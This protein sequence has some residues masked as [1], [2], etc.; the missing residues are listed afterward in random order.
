MSR[1]EFARRVGVT[2]LTIYR[3]ELPLDADESRRPRKR[4]RARLQQLAADGMADPVAEAPVADAPVAGQ[5]GAE[6][7]PR[8][9]EAS[10]RTRPRRPLRPVP[11]SP[12]IDLSDEKP[13]VHSG[14]LA[15]HERAAI[16]PVLGDIAYANWERAEEELIE[17]LAAGRLE[18]SGRALA[19]LSMA[20]IQL[21]GRNDARGAFS[22]LLP[23]LTTAALGELSEAAAFRAHMVAT[24]LF[25]TPYGQLFDAGRVRA[26]LARG[27]RLP[28]PHGGDDMRILL[29][30]GQLQGPYHLGDQALFA[31]RLLRDRAELEA[32]DQPVARCLVE[33][34]LARAAYLEGHLA[35]AQKRFMA[36]AERA[37][38]R[39]FSLV[40]GQALAYAALQTLESA[41]PADSALSLCDRA[42][43][44]AERARLEPGAHQLLL[45][46]V[47]A[48]AHLRL[49]QRGAAQ[50][51]LAR[52]I[53]LAER[54]G[55]PPIDLLFG[56]V[57]A[58]TSPEF[59]RDLRESLGRWDGGPLHAP[60]AAAM[61]FVD[62]LLAQGQGQIDE[63]VR[64]FEQAAGAAQQS[65]TRPWLASY[66]HVLAYGNAVLT[67]D[68]ERARRALRRA[69]RLQDRLPGA[70]YTAMLRGY[71]G[72]Y[73][74]L[75]R[76]RDESLQQT[77]AALAI[78]EQAGD[79][80][81]LI[82]G[83]HTLA[84][85]AQL[86]GDPSA[87]AQLEQAEGRLRELGVTL[88]P[89]LR[90]EALVRQA[91]PPTPTTPAEAPPL[92][93]ALSVP[94]ARLAVRGSTPLKILHELH[95]IVG[96]LAGQ[97]GW[98]DEIDSEGRALRLLAGA[99]HL[100]SEEPAAVFEFGDGCGRRFRLGFERRLSSSAMALVQTL[101]AV[102]ALALEVA[103]LRSIG[104]V[105]ATEEVASGPMLLAGII[106]HSRQMREL[107]RD[108]TRLA[109][110]RATVMITGES[111]TGKE[112]LARAI[113]QQSP[114]AQRP[115]VTFN[116]AAV[117]REL[118]E[119]QLFGYRKG[120]FTGATS[121]HSGVVRA[122]DHG[123]LFLDE[124]GDL[125]IEMQPK[126]LRFLENGE[127][128]P[129]G[130]NSPVRV[131]VRVVAATHRDLDEMIR[132][133]LFREDL[134]YR[135]QVVTL[136]IP[137]LRERL[138]DILPL[139][140]FFIR[141]LVPAESEAPV[142]SQD[143]IKLL[144]SHHWPGNVREVRNVIERALA[145]S[146]LPT[147]LTAEHLRL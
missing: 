33:L 36:L 7:A 88:P 9:T 143:A 25:A 20:T 83:R 32:A 139:T 123:T 129:L 10:A 77:E 61:L 101:L 31:R 126:L 115:Y 38:E 119:G 21:L 109:G 76:R 137:P 94:V 134:F 41:G 49:G 147:V 55:W 90:A 112:V 66:A 5:G 52:G 43:R 26:H 141:N 13:P 50:R 116:C 51:T 29:R 68:A 23:V 102:A 16:L 93:L 22:T 87:M 135:V 11:S 118:F 99:E 130:E 82:V 64:F 30:L 18:T 73:L 81:Q 62:G 2:P 34:T 120:A 17:I 97:G 14:N 37:A 106:A 128:L 108:V 74:C 144:L 113:H 27:E 70:W 45:A 138:D 84:L 57:R 54:I 142:L 96:E 15:P 46:G 78:F 127:V 47:R 117:P 145:Y 71:R 111:G 75:Q 8:E 6:P 72:I 110:S 19:Q 1:A 95:T 42:S 80:P 67:G 91:T 44:S 4:W 59:L 65:G 56:V 89:Q 35:E 86:S 3:W 39:G 53:D 121:S 105:P 114:R 146:P 131:D 140:R 28:T 133:G 60:V 40:E 136:Q 107:A 122:A 100:P 124:I 69:E 92:A 79:L 103:A 85:A 24:L 98:I 132:E 63:A 104:E 12:I 125:P 58:E 48:E